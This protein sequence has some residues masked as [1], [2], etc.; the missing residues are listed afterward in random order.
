MTIYL[1]LVF[2]ENVCMNSIILFTTG[3]VTKTR[4]KFLRILIS[5]TIGAFYVVGKYLANSEI[6]S[7]I[8]I[9]LG[10]AFAMVYIAFSPKNMKWLFKYVIIFYLT[11][12]V[13]GGCAFALLYYVKPQEILYN[14]G[15]LTGTYPIKIAFLGAMVGLIFLNI[16]FKL[17]KNRLNKNDMFCNVII[18]Y[19]DKEFKIRAIIDSGNLLKEPITGASVVV[20]EKQKL[21]EI[22]ESEILENLENIISGQ[23]EILND[24]YIS[25]FRL[26]PFSSLGKQ[27][28]MF[29]GFKPDFFEIEFDGITTRKE[30]IVIGIYEKEISKYKEYN[31]IVGLDVLEEDKLGK[32]EIY[33]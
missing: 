9:Q 10:L 27:N 11:S 8:F 16:A 22:I 33:R 25:R 24:D 2:I 3:L 5:S 15:I 20:V 28:G 12:F 13:F 32:G 18:G 26:I 17:I 23:Y 21:E 7:N 6:Y 31:A 30:K 29:L 14:N 19:K 1:D 4:T